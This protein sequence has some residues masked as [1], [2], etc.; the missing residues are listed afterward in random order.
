M[1]IVYLVSHS[2]PKAWVSRAVV[3]VP[4]P[5]DHA[6]Q[7][8]MFCVS[9]FNH[10]SL[11]DLKHLRLQM[12]AEPWPLP[13]PV[14][15][16]ALRQ[17]ASGAVQG[18]IETPGAVQGRIETP[19][20]LQGRIETPTALQGRI[21][22]PGAVQGNLTFQDSSSFGSVH[23]AK[24]SRLSRWMSRCQYPSN[25][26]DLNISCLTLDRSQSFF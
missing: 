14:G 11:P 26:S 2:P 16:G 18:R 24:G 20:A 3:P 10:H 6:M 1:I 4:L 12:A 23:F 9:T 7:P 25:L 15:G 5:S 8:T 17:M 21:E 13:L 22:T 19:T